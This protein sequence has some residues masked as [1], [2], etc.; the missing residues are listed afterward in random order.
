MGNPFDT[1]DVFGKPI[2]ESDFGDKVLGNSGSVRQ[3][4]LGDILGG[5]AK[6]VRS[7]TFGDR[8]TG[9]SQ[10]ASESDSWLSDSTAI[11]RK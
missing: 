7:S 1:D 2:H 6:K 8:V 3:A 10:A 4:G 11:Y 9:D 5:N